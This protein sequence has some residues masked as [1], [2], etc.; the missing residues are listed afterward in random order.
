MYVFGYRGDVGATLIRDRRRLD[1]SYVDEPSHVIEYGYYCREPSQG[2]AYR[3]GAVYIDVSF[4]PP[5][6]TP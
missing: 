2:L 1:G 3:L 4:L 5:P 6:S